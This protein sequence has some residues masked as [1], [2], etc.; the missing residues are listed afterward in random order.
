MAA[1]MIAMQF[2]DAV[3]SV[4]TIALCVPSVALTPR[5]LWLLGQWLVINHAARTI[6]ILVSSVFLLKQIRQR[7]LSPVREC[8][9]FFL[10]RVMGQLSWRIVVQLSWSIVAQLHVGNTSYDEILAFIFSLIPSGL[11]SLLHNFTV[12]K[13]WKPA[14]WTTWLGFAALPIFLKDNNIPG[15]H[16]VII[17]YSNVILWLLSLLI[18]CG[19][20]WIHTSRKNRP[21][22]GTGE[23]QTNVRVIESTTKDSQ[24]DDRTCTT[25]HALAPSP[26][27]AFSYKDLED[28]AP[29]GKEIRMLTILQS[30]SS[31]TSE[32]LKCRIRN[33][34]TDKAQ[35]YTALS[36]EWGSENATACVEINGKMMAIRPNLHNALCVMRNHGHGDI[37]VDAICIDQETVDEV[38]SHMTIIKKIYQGADQ[39]AAWLGPAADMSDWIMDELEKGTRVV[40][41]A[42]IHR[43]PGSV[44]DTA[45]TKFL[46]RTYWQ[47][48]WIVQEVAVGM[49]VQLYCGMKQ[50][51]WRN[52]RCFRDE[53]KSSTDEKQAYPF[54]RTVYEIRQHRRISSQRPKNTLEILDLTRAFEA[55]NDEDKVLGLLG[56]AEDWESYKTPPDCFQEPRSL[57]LSMTKGVVEKD[58]T[59]DIILLGRTYGPQIPFQ[60]RKK[61]TPDQ[62]QLPSWCPD[63]VHFA[64]TVSE[65]RLISYLAGQPMHI[66]GRRSADATGS[67]LTGKIS[68][69]T[70]GDYDVLNVQGVEIGSITSLGVSASLPSEPDHKYREI[71]QDDSWDDTELYNTLGQTLL[72]YD[73]DYDVHARDPTFLLWIMDERRGFLETV[74]SG[75]GTS[76]TDEARINEWL[77]ANADM[78]I[79]GETLCTRATSLSSKISGTSNWFKHAV[80]TAIALAQ[81]KT[82]NLSIRARG[83]IVAAIKSAIDE[84]LRLMTLSQGG[85]MGW[86]P[87]NATLSDKVFLLEGCHFP[88]VL[89]HRINQRDKVMPGYR[90]VGHAYVHGVMHNEVWSKMGTEDLQPLSLY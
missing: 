84:D 41:I 26:P 58:E 79:H 23:Q 50:T 62:R 6:W 85:R 89:R 72:M 87:P 30:D 80:G 48:V 29:E 7:H 33:V 16:A 5:L 64:P 63:F 82:S 51:A 55:T 90:V 54:A 56:L 43:R 71:W 37:W 31:S 65:K 68:F 77:K 22:V 25:T 9:S 67:S 49:R 47:R 19:R 83:H 60:R 66:F 52:L 21:P 3:L 78:Y 36:Y 10:Y 18:S 27:T 15:Y 17:I 24:L 42:P 76:A 40:D 88:V 74:F 13:H 45:V 11:S 28:L 12:V 8:A 35:G 38:N 73:K 20:G 32:P 39:V 1:R 4:L 61:N 86:A 2:Y 70:D 46:T 75:A 34:A 69:T 59:L 57:C 81:G 53:W 44:E 14:L